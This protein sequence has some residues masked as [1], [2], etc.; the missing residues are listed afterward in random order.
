MFFSLEVFL[1]D[2]MDISS[3]LLMKLSPAS[4]YVA[5]QTLGCILRKHIHAFQASVVKGGGA[6]G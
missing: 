4:M 2:I 5:Q 6:R 1:Y 3:D